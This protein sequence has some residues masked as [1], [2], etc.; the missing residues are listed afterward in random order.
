MRG[1]YVAL[2]STNGLIAI[3]SGARSRCVRMFP[4]KIRDVVLRVVCRA[5][6]NRRNFRISWHTFGTRRK[7]KEGSIYA[8]PLISFGRRP[9][10]RTPNQ[11][12]KSRLDLFYASIN[13]SL[14][15]ACHSIQMS[16]TANQ[17]SLEGNWGTNLAQSMEWS[18]PTTRPAASPMSRTP[19]LQ[20]CY[21]MAAARFARCRIRTL[22]V[23][24]GHRWRPAHPQ[25]PSG[26]RPL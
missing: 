2:P 12:I 20:K 16:V 7:R 3:W 4:R 24:G 25:R 9:G 23:Q 26:Q 11:R 10:T 15:N 21:L 18:R 17:I 6:R 14:S 19:L 13:Q 8:N 22:L 5:H 1:I